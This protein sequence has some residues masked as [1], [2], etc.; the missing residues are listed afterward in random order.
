M[1][2]RDSVHRKAIELGK[3]IIRMTTAAGSGHPSSG[4][5]IAHIVATLMYDVMRWRPDDPWDPASD[6]LVLSE[7]HAVPA[8]YAAYADLGGV[9]GRDRRSAKKLTKADLASLRQ[10]GSPLDGHPNPAEGFPFFDAATGSLGQGL[11]VGAGLALAARRRNLDRRFFVIIGDGESREGQIWE[12]M[13]LI[14]DY[15][16]T[17]VVAVFNSNGQGQADYVSRQQSAEVLSAK[18]AAFGWQPV[19]ID[20]HDPDALKAALTDT[21]KRTQC[22]AIIARTEKGWGCPSL[23][24]KSNHGKPVPADKLDAVLAELDG[25]YET[26]NV[27]REDGG[28]FAPSSPPA[29]PS[30]EVRDV[31]PVP[32]DKAIAEAGMEA[33]LAKGKLA[34]R[35]AYGAALLALGGA[36]E[37]IVALDGDVRNSTFSEL[38]AKRYPDRFVECKIAEQNMVS[39]AVGM[40]AAGMIPFVSTFAKFASRAYDQVE[41]AQI[42]RA[43]IKITGSH[44]GVSLAADGPSQMS[45]HD[46]AYFRCA[47][48]TD[49]GR[50][51]PVCVVFHPSDAVSAYHCTWLMGGH[52]GMC[53]MR[54]HRPEVPLLYAPDTRFE[55][56]GSHTLTKGDALT[57]V[58]AG[59]MLHVCKEAVARVASE[60]GI[61]CTLIDAYSF[62]LDARPILSAAKETGGRVL[63]VEDNYVGGLWSAVAEAAALSGECRVRGMTCR[64][65][66]KSTPTSDEIMAYVGL[67]AADVVTE[68]RGILA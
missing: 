8:V 19:M 47:S 59:Y 52:D 62:P 63:C 54:T 25:L 38:F 64:K 27:P 43:N 18:A 50:G 28:A 37:R 65:M 10:T 67:S 61:R 14:A 35:K 58:S 55:I 4:L 1:A 17:N 46:V 9:V 68:I 32:F 24:D 57:V 49:D 34:T 6:R 40:A 48:L 66:P 31:S 2:Y 44:A 11:S 39:T 29:V 45:L 15:G 5:S 33:A 42:T 53:Y 20:G 51:K 22:L 26:L 23:K 7:G 16:L 41:M 12:A 56:G 36:D 60:A 13:D 3:D 21:G 30:L